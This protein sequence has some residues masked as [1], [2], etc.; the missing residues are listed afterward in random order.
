MYISENGFYVLLKGLLSHV[1]V[2]SHAQRCL[3]MNMVDNASL[4]PNSKWIT[5]KFKP[6]LVLDT[7]LYLSR[8]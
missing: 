2:T 8:M 1:L 5:F 7:E 4:H 3:F 6:E